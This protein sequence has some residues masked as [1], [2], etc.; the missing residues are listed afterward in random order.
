M[1]ISAISLTDIHKEYIRKMGCSVPKVFN[2]TDG[3]YER[4]VYH[5]RE[6]H[7]KD[8]E[9]MIEA[10]AI[11][12]I[13]HQQ[14]ERPESSPFNPQPYLIAI[15]VLLALILLV[16]LRARSSRVV[17]SLADRV[18]SILVD[19]AQHVQLLPADR[20]IPNAPA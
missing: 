4:A 16:G 2:C 12:R 9:E 15:I 11:A 19:P 3:E 6:Q 13:V 10:R 14:Q 5:A 8:T 18:H 17:R 20:S 7:P 1:R